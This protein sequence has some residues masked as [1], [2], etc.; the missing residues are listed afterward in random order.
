MKTHEPGHIIA[1]G[2]S[3]GGMEEI[4]SFF[5]H[6]PLDG[7]AYVIVQHL[8]PDFKSRMVELLARHSKLEVNEAANG[9]SVK[10]NQVYL[11]PNDKF[12][13]IKDEKLY[14]TEKPK[15]GPHLTINTFFNSLAENCGKKAIAVI[16]SG[17]GSD[18]TEGIKAV[19]TAGGMT[20]ARNPESSDF[21]SMPTSAIA[22]GCVDFTLEPAAMPRTIEDYVNQVESVKAEQD[23]DKNYI[24][25]IIDFIR[26]KSPLDFSDYKQT[27][28]LRRTKRKAVSKGFAS[29]KGY[30]DFLKITPQEVED[31][32]QEYLISVTGFFR[33]KEAFEY[34]QNQALPTLLAKLL[35][36][37]EL[38]VW[39]AGCA[40]GEEAYSMAIMIHEQLNENSEDQVI[41]IFA[42]DIDNAALVIAGKGV[43][44]EEIKKHLSAKR[45]DKYFI[46]EG[47][48][49][50]VKPK[51]R[52]MVIFAQHDL[53][54]NPPFCNMH[55]I[56]CRN[57]LIYMTPV[58]QQKV[59]SMLQFGLRMEGYLFLGSSENPVS[60]LENLEICDKKHKVYKNMETKHAVRFDAFSL[61]LLNTKKTAASFPIPDNADQALTEQVN[62]SLLKDLDYL[63]L[64]VDEHNQV[65]KTYGDTTQ[66]LL[67]K[68]FTSNL[69]ELLPRQ[70]A[71]A[72][73][74]LSAKV[75]K[76]GKKSTVSGIKLENQKSVIKVTLSVGPLTIKKS[77]KNLLLLSISPDQLNRPEQAV[78]VFDEKI[79]HDQYTIN[80]EEELNELK[81]KLHSAHLQL[82]TSNENMQSFNEELLSANEEMQSTNEEMQSVNEELHTINSD[83]QLK[84]K[85]LL[86]L[87]DDLNN[88][89]R[90]NINGQL[91]VNKDL[92]LM[93]FSPG[94]VKQIN[95]LPSDL[96]RPLSHISTNIK[97]ETFIEDIKEVIEEGIIIT[98][99]IEANDGKWYQIMTMPYLQ[100]VDNQVN[101][102]VITFN[103]I[104]QLKKTQ[105]EL[106]KRNQSLMR[107]N[108]DLDNFVHSASHDLL[109]PLG[110][111]ESSIKVMNRI[112]V[113]DPQ[114][115]KFLNI[116]NNSIKKFRVLINDI[117]VIGKL[118][119]DMSEMVDLEEILNNV[120]WSLADKISDSKALIT[121]QL[122]IS[123]I[124]F[125]K[126]NL[127]S[128]I[129]NLV[130]N[131]LKFSKGKPPVINISSSILNDN[132]VLF[133]QDN[134]IGIEK[135]KISQIF[136]MYGRLNYA[137]E[138]QGIGLFLVKKIIDAANGSILV[139][140]E[141]GKGTKFLI[142][143]KAEPEQLNTPKL[144]GS[145]KVIDSI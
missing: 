27:T 43:Y 66:Y 22:T 145:D 68:N 116:I 19:K 102:A 119:Q 138:G 3:A 126:K 83:Y 94:T 108:E 52:R 38:K 13:T 135:E 21:G 2:A 75:L 63:I 72:F 48:T 84:N 79:Y 36:D 120:E 47:N 70:L 140:S 107:I 58:L 56:S 55:L 143:L 139:E 121:R 109:G 117:S 41:K 105:L 87:N 23:E 50:R 51:I 69:I 34:I 82:D 74:T 18:G 142:Y 28:I 46:K 93:R 98:K 1:I 127:R 17:L 124:R 104:T 100:Q 26:E 16:L 12:M 95:L 101:G 115:S 80:L 42:T 33:D 59:L 6:T 7:V 15:K 53:V 123:H 44:N 111:I 73:N 64:C 37:E 88:Y 128:I 62:E 110:N 132:I 30:L 137:I 134:G 14:L 136:E 67:Q 40:T 122:E 49:Y 89:F 9:M 81:E 8:S 71:V 10:T 29:L 141:P 129:Y 39:V 118:E 11:I 32:T 60:I 35:P 86:E 131:A 65:V 85:E 20:I 78:H 99:E 133:V 77:G 57:L 103:D 25:L 61:P 91:F 92:L 96:G 144:A 106:D 125:S 5:D 90:S 45:L 4:N 54:K 112:K 114:L 97:F 113:T 31:L 76:T 130:S 24:K